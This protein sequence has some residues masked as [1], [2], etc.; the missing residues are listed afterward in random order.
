MPIA[1]RIHRTNAQLTNCEIAGRV[2]IIRSRIPPEYTYYARCPEHRNRYVL[3]FAFAFDIEEDVYQFALNCPYTCTQLEEK[4]T[5][6]QVAGKKQLERYAMSPF[7]AKT[8][9]SM[10][11]QR[12]TI[13]VSLVSDFERQLYWRAS[14][15]IMLHNLL[16]RLIA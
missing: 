13:A 5:F 3:T 8:V 14:A 1:P 7:G 4:L 11:F 2:A 15:I 12:D 16:A 9:E 6:W 10:F